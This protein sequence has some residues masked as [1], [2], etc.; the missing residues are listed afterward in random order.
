MSRSMPQWRCI[1]GC[2]ACCRLD[3]ELRPEAL[4]L[5]DEEQSRAYLAMVGE[6][7]W[8][9]HYDTGGQRCRIYDSRPSFC[10]VDTIMT[11]LGTAGEA[12]DRLAIR[13]CQQQIRSESGGRGKVMRR[14]QR[15]LR[16]P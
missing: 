4:A 7:G 14:F 15:A 3:P 13:F 9:I 12:A 6:D 5:L 2:G 8:C 10:R 11:L 1:Q 16:Q